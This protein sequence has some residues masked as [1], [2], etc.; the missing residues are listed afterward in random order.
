MQRSFEVNRR[1]H[2]HPHVLGLHTRHLVHGCR[3]PR[4]GP[5]K[6]NDV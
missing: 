6:R 3:A 1:R 4:S 5:E 2:R